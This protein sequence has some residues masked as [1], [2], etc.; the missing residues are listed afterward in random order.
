MAKFATAAFVGCF[1]RLSCRNSFGKLWVFVR[2]FELSELC[3]NLGLVK[4]LVFG[5]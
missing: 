3:R 2:G 5:W 4:G 1:E